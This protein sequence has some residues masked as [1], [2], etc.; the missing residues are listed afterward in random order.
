[1]LCIWD[2]AVSGNSNR[3]ANDAQRWTRT[4]GG[5]NRSTARLVLD[6]HTAAVKAVSWCPWSRHTLASGG[7]TAD[8]TIRMWNS[9][10]G[11]LC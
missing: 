1:M 4:P 6:Q 7:G 3:Q 2:A 8:R 9:H 10:T 11:K 5:T